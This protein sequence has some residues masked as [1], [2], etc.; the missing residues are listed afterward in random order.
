VGASR[1][2]C[3]CSAKGRDLNRR[4]EARRV[5]LKEFGDTLV[6]S[7]VTPFKTDRFL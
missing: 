5:V 1:V 6:L 4:A 3:S 2:S 7:L